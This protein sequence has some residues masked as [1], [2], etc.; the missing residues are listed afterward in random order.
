ME[1]NSH[2]MAKVDTSRLYFFLFLSVGC[3]CIGCPVLIYPMTLDFWNF[4]NAHHLVMDDDFVF[5]RLKLFILVS[6]AISSAAWAHLLLWCESDLHGF[7]HNLDTCMFRE[8]SCRAL[9]LLL[10][11]LRLLLHLLLLFYHLELL[12][13]FL[14][15]VRFNFFDF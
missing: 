14:V 7:R 8:W 4:F 10:W 2:L 11:L 5:W 12:R 15:G 13:L 6:I 1:W 3:Q 9:R